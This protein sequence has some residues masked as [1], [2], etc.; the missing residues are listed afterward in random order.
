M[1]VAP[2]NMTSN[3]ADITGSVIKGPANSLEPSSAVKKFKTRQRYACGA[4][5][6]SFT[7]KLFHYTRELIVCH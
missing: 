7:K 5:L 2:E 3:E 4:F 1:S 6:Q